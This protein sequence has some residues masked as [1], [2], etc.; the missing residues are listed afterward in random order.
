M[1]STTCIL[2]IE[3]FTNQNGCAHWSHMY[4]YMYIYIQYMNVECNTGVVLLRYKHHYQVLIIRNPFPTRKYADKLDRLDG[5]KASWVGYVV[6][7]LTSRVN[8]YQEA[9]LK[10][11]ERAEMN[12]YQQRLQPPSSTTHTGW[13]FVTTVFQRN[14]LSEVNVYNTLPHFLQCRLKLVRPGN[15]TRYARTKPA[16]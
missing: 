3:I 11:S 7:T 9:S 12:Y 15:F 13:A 8:V 4:L 10:S 1:A 2:Y 6:L 16:Q 5:H 14:H